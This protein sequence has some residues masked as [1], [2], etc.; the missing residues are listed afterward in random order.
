MTVAI[1]ATVLAL[2]VLLLTWVGPAEDAFGGIVLSLL[3]LGVAG[4][5]WLGVLIG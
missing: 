3:V 2:A 5:V 1:G 4:G